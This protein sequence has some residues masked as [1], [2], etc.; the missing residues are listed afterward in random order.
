MRIVSY[1]ILNGAEG[2][3]D[4]VAEVLEARRPDVAAL[5]EAD[6]PAVVERIAGRLGMDAIEAVG[7]RHSIAILS[8]FP[9]VATINHSLLCDGFSDAILEAH[10]VPPGRPAMV[11]VAVHLYPYATE[12]AERKREAEI[13][14]LLERLSAHR[15][16]RQ[17]HVLAGDFNANSP[18]QKIDPAA[19][20]PRTRQE[21]ADNGGGVPRRAI[22][23]LLDAGYADTLAVARRADAESA[24]TF[25]TQSPG[26]R[27]DYIFSHSILPSAIRSAWIERDR[28]AKYASDHFPVGV[29][30]DW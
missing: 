5:I 17:A 27:V 30:L 11:V 12:E 3:A 28:L 10:I 29:E 20:K 9:I 7:R 8:R 26:Q 6:Q 15:D 23:K 4:P 22:R 19:C 25:S 14:A 2:R 21:W 16:A 1:N 13:D 24:G 18:I